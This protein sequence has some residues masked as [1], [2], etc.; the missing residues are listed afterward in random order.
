MRGEKHGNAQKKV[1]VRTNFC[2]WG[3]K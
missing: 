2:A 1:R 3:V